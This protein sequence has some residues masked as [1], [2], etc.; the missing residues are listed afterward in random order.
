M[1]LTV[2]NFPSWEPRTIDLTGEARART[3]EYTFGTAALASTVTTETGVPRLGL[4]IEGARYGGPLPSGGRQ[5]SG[6]ER[7]VLLRGVRAYRSIRNALESEWVGE[8]S[9]ESVGVGS[10]PF[11]SPR[12]DWDTTI[13]GAYLVRSAGG[14]R[15]VVRT[16]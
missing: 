16:T 6:S 12:G 5:G 2:L 9:L 1:R 11:R 3:I 15:D 4:H 13:N 14:D 7:E 10:G 8:R